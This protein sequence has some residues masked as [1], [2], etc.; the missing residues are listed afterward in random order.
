MAV[1]KLMSAAS[2][3]QSQASQPRLAE[4]ACCAFQECA[5]PFW[6][7]LGNSEP[8]CRP[9]SGSA[10]LLQAAKEIGVLCPCLAYDDSISDTKRMQSDHGITILSQSTSAMMRIADKNWIGQYQSIIHTNA[11]I[12]EKPGIVKQD[13]DAN[14]AMLPLRHK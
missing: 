8:A 3:I 5:A 14:S 6:S 10:N 13:R 7:R 11:T 1:S 9:A 12:G 4:P 2:P